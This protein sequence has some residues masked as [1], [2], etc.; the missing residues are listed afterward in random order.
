MA[1]SFKKWERITI[2]NAFPKNL[3]ESNGKPNKI[4]VDKCSG[5][6]DSGMKS[7]P[8]INAIDIY[9]TYKEQKS[10]VPVWFIRALENKTCK[11]ITSISNYVYVEIL[12]KI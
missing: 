10:V 12:S 7:W 3:D 4:L 5:I 6:Y 11:S 1:Y 2:A 8:E 9:S